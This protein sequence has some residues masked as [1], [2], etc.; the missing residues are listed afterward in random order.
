M[1]VGIIASNILL[2]YA[3]MIGLRDRMHQVIGRS[4]IL[5]SD[6]AFGAGAVFETNCMGFSVFALTTIPCT[7]I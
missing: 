3:D 2:H 1:L 7:K 6:L 5:F 4:M